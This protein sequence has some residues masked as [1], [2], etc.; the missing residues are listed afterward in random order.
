MRLALSRTVARFTPLICSQVQILKPKR[1]GDWDYLFDLTA[2]RLFR[3]L[4]LDR[5]LGLEAD[6]SAYRWQARLLDGANKL[7]SE[8]Q[9]PD[10]YDAPETSA[11]ASVRAGYEPGDG[12]S[13]ASE[14]PA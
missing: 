6:G 13:S 9:L 2:A 4:P 8:G 1:D 12:A 3:S 7:R 14:A 11:G 10:W 5:D